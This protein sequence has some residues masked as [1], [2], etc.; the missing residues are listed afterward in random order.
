[1][2][3]RVVSKIVQRSSRR[4]GGRELGAESKGQGVR[5]HPVT[6]LTPALTEKQMYTHKILSISSAIHKQTNSCECEYTLRECACVYVYA[7][8][9]VC[10]C[11]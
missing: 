8:V 4:A 9:H 1:M 5:Q 3:L 7:C 11:V 10:V 2:L 6:A